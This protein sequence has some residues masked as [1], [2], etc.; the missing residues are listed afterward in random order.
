MNPELIPPDKTQADFRILFEGEA[1]DEGAIKDL[2][3]VLLSFSSVIEAANAA[4]HKDRVQVQVK[5][6]AIDK[7]SF[8]TRLC[9]HFVSKAPANP[10]PIAAAHQTLDL[11]LVRELLALYIV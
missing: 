5:V 10:E 6:R 4:L 3:A 8:V 1:F 2:A 9:T 11:V 7:G